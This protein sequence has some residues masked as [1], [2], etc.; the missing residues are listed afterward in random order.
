MMGTNPLRCSAQV[1]IG[2][3]SFPSR[4][5]SARAEVERLLGGQTLTAKLFSLHFMQQ[6]TQTHVRPVQLRLRNT[7]RAPEHLCD[8]MM[9]IP[10]DIVQNKYGAI[11]HRQLRDAASKVYSVNRSLQE[12]VGGRNIDV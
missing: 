12:Q 2:R 4:P 1:P 9:F 10:L 6:F 3:C 8:L 11:A 5:N 7:Y